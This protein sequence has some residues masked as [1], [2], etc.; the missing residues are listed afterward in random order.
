M[1]KKLKTVNYLIEFGSILETE[2][3][4]ILQKKHANS[5]K[6]ILVDE[7]TN[8]HCLNYLITNFDE[9]SE[10]E[11]I[12]IPSGEENKVMEICVQVWETLSEYQISRSD[13]LISLGGGMVTDMG[14]FIAS[15]Y[16]RGIDFV[17]IPTSLLAMVD[18][19]VGGKTGVDLGRYKNQLGVFSDPK[20]IYI[21][22]AFLHTLPKEEKMNG[23]A[24]MIKHGLIADRK[25]WENLNKIS[26]DEVDLNL[27]YDSVGIKN[28]IVTR[29]PLEK[30]ERKK[31]NFGHTFG[32]AFEGFL[33]HTEHKIPHG[34]AVALG[35][36]C[37]TY[38]SFVKEKIR[39]NEFNEIISFLR[40][41]YSLLA[42]QEE[43]YE[44]LYQLMKQD[45]KN[46]Q[47][48]ILCVLL[49]AI[50]ESIIDQELSKEE[51][52]SDFDYLLKTVKEK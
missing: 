13:L 6:V 3:L 4:D 27:I 22:P 32:H 8:E 9:L 1:K 36:F 26:V 14:G 45:K 35:M 31:L 34:Y 11:I 18:A 47:D 24:E 25:H 41:H 46:N 40:K 10:A 48:R 15:I 17:S 42:F 33:L 16:K 29:D 52:F 38:L 5:K 23:F 21:D 7:N 28:E 50:G 19:S 44:E 39:E 2:F 37:E 51:V 30:N 49:S 43:D 12:V 20:A